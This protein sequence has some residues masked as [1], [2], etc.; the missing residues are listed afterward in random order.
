VCETD[1]FPL[2]SLSLSLSHHAHTCDMVFLKTQEDVDECTKIHIKSIS[3]LSLSLFLSVCV[4]A[5]QFF[6]LHILR[7]RDAMLLQ[8]SRM[9][10]FLNESRQREREAVEAGKVPKIFAP[11]LLLILI[12]PIPTLSSLSH[13]L[14]SE[15]SHYK[16]GMS[17]SNPCAGRIMTEKLSAGCSL[18]TLSSLF[19]AQ[20]LSYQNMFKNMSFLSN[21]LII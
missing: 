6:L 8:S 16:S 13:S 3:S 9:Y 17:K 19:C 21:L 10:T 2:L 20:T 7:S 12:A 1:V 5:G 11:V 15:V 14:T 18:E 4:C